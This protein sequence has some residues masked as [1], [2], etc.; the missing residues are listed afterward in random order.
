LC[1]T[2]FF[3]LK[4][5]LLNFAEIQVGEKTKIVG[6]IY[7]GNVINIKIGNNCWLG[8]NLSLD[9]DG[10]VIIGDNVDI[11]PHVTINTGG[12]IIG[13]KYRRAGKG[14]NNIIEIKNGCWVGSNCLMVNS[15][16]I[17]KS[18]VIAAGSVVIKDIPNNVL[19]AGVPVTI[20][21]R[22]NND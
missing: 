20:K 1:C 9:G 11:A 6:P 16:I 4:R 15:L 22:L 12:H 18:T 19:V 21:R 13:D 14:I 5:K 10:T 2:R 7:F 17:G 8:R 3:E